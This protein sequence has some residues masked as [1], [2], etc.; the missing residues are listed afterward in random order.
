MTLWSLTRARIYNKVYSR[1]IVSCLALLL[2]TACGNTGTRY[3]I[4]VSQCSDDNWREKMND[5]MLSSVYAEGD[6]TLD[7]VSAGDN[8]ELQK[9]Q[10][11]EFVEKN[12]DLIIV[13]PNQAMPISS[14]LQKAKEKG[15]PVICVD[16]KAEEFVYDAFIGADNVNA[17][18]SVG[19]FLAS[20]LHGKGVIVEFEGL[21]G[22]SPAA[23]RNK[24]FLEALKDTPGIKVINGGN[25]DWTTEGAERTIETFIRQHPDVRPDAIFGHNDRIAVTAKKLYQKHGI[26]V[27]AVGVDALPNRDGGLQ[28]VASGEL[29]ASYLY[30]TRGDLII[31]L[32]KRILNGEKVEKDTY[33]SSALITHDNAEAVLA[34]T[35]DMLQMQRRI[36]TLNS[37]IDGF[38]R[39]INIQRTIFILSFVIVFLVIFITVYVFREEL[40]KRKRIEAETN[41]RLRF[42]T[43][44]SHEFRTPLTLIAD[45]LDRIDRSK[46][47]SGNNAQ[48]LSL[49]KRQVDI[50]LRLVSDFLDLR[51]LQ[52][53][54]MTLNLKEVDIA[55]A[56][57]HWIEGFK[58]MA[59]TKGVGIRLSAPQ[60]LIVTTDTGKLE[61][62]GYN[63]LSNALKYSPPSTIIEV[64]LTSDSN[65]FV[66]TVSDQGKGMTEEEVSRVFIRFYQTSSAVSGTGIGLAFVKELVD[67]M[68]GSIDIKSSLGKGTSFKVAIPTAIQKVSEEKQEKY[69]F[70]DPAEVKSDDVTGSGEETDTLVLVV[71]DN[72]DVRTYLRDTIQQAGYKV[73]EASDGAS[74][75]QSAT[76]NVPDIVVSDVMMPVMDGHEMCRRL[77]S[78]TAT[79]HIPVLMLTAQVMD[80]QRTEGYDAGVDAYITK[81]FSSHVLL[82]RLK[83]LLKNRML[84]KVVFSGE[85]KSNKEMPVS[86][87]AETISRERISD[88]SGSVSMENAFLTSFREQV[89][90]HMIETDFTVETLAS[91]LNLS[92]VQM[93]RKIKA[94]TGQ[95]PVELIREARL[96]RA[97]KMLQTGSYTI[98]EVAYSVGFSSP[99]YFTKC[100]KQQFGH[101]PGEK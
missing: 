36:S 17:G 53:K 76:E 21:A 44:V 92:R 98:S 82:S 31:D 75:L 95:N 35:D 87:Q 48:L 9:M 25:T 37:Q 41:E 78:Q 4:G 99:S 65:Q 24:G 86:E 38:L 10:I 55:E 69:M 80:D 72:A 83:N 70:V 51:K 85:G 88:N 23:E 30:P 93:Y 6:I 66:L 91:N 43:N 56:F 97:D 60:Q 68:G 20:R 47:L 2:F 28:K 14:E 49:A 71:D 8:N 96:L 64:S 67:M 11:A 19:Q 5:E 62:I 89:E 29:E 34:Q 79:S 74:G 59:E 7:I 90:Q 22:S 27:I 3:V 12:V 54:K 100:Y 77:K 57:R 45:P 73:I 1:V 84:L 50:M 61:R 39:Q 40:A 58:P 101:T 94:L 52:D 15:I 81:P 26:D 16:R 13:A 32:A 18:R 63:L 46:E 42:F 33:L